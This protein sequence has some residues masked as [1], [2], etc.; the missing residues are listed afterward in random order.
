MITRL[1]PKEVA[2][3][4]RKELKEAFPGVKFSVRTSL[5]AGGSSIDVRWTD[6]PTKD[7]VGQVAGHLKGADFDGMQDLKIYRNNGYGND[8]IFFNR[9]FSVE[10]LNDAARIISDKYGKPTPEV[11]A[12]TGGTNAYFADS[13]DFVNGSEGDYNWNM[14]T[15]SNREARAMSADEVKVTITNLDQETAVKENLANLASLGINNALG[16]A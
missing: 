11:K 10:F 7:E 4:A 14:C 3:I 16:A 2:K 15:V 12:H 6:G 9:D 5:Y 1:A 13:Y 8:F